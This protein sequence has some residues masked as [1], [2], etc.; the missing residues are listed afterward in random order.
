MR[1]QAI[2]LRIELVEMRKVAHA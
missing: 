2:D 1:G